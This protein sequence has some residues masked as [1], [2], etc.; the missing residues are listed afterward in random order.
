MKMT[1]KAI[2][3][4]IG[5]FQW[6]LKPE[7]LEPLPP[8]HSRP[9]AAEAKGSFISWLVQPERLPRDEVDA[10]EAAAGLKMSDLLFSPETIGQERSPGFKRP[11]PSFIRWLLSGERLGGAEDDK[12]ETENGVSGG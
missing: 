7:K 3:K 2:R 6:I 12:E 9:A 8:N 5:F 11:R 4:T 1:G 10:R